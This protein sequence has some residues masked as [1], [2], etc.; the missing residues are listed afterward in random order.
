MSR[1]PKEETISRLKVQ[2]K[3]VRKGVQELHSM[4]SEVLPTDEFRK[5]LDTIS[6]A[7]QSVLAKAE[8][9]LRNECAWSRR[10]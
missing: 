3:I 7:V 8:Y 10:T 2:G 1:L 6:S 9:C 4:L 5:D